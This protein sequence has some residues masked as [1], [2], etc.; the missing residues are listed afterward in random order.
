[1]NNSRKP[2]PN[3]DTYASARLRIRMGRLPRTER[4]DPD[5]E[6]AQREPEELLEPILANTPQFSPSTPSE[7]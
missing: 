6:L 4:G 7:S 3:L 5:Q 2:V 1:M